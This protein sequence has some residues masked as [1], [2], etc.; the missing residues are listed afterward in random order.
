MSFTE[1]RNKTFVCF[2]ALFSAEGWFEEPVSV[3]G[4]TDVLHQRTGQGHCE[5]RGE[6]QQE[7]ATILSAN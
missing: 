4:A 6:L 1:D 7:L 5:E 3:R 2:C